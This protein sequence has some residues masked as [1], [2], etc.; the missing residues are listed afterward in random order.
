MRPK[1]CVTII[2]TKIKHNMKSL[3]NVPLSLGKRLR[4]KTKPGNN[5]ATETRNL[6]STNVT[7]ACR[8]FN[9]TFIIDQ[10]EPHSNTT[11]TN[12]SQ[13]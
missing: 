3:T 12:N 8:I 9:S 7:G 5:T 10:L 1:A 13:F 2:D 6:C 11:E 4:N